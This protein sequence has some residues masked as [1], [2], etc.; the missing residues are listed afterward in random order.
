MLQNSLLTRVAPVAVGVGV[1]VVA[2]M[3]YIRP[4]L[5]PTK[6]AS[7]RPVFVSTSAAASSALSLATWERDEKTKQE[8]FNLGIGQPAPSLLPTAAVERASARLATYDSRH[9]LQ[10]VESAA[11][12]QARGSGD[13]RAG[14]DQW[15]PLGLT[16]LLL[17]SVG[18]AAS[19][20]NWWSTTVQPGT[21]RGDATR[22][23][24]P[25]LQAA[26]ATLSRGPVMVS[27]A[28]NRSD[29]ALV[30]RSCTRDG[31]LLHPGA[32]AVLMDGAVLARAQNR[33]WGEVWLAPTALGGRRR[34]GSWLDWTHQ[35]RGGRFC[36]CRRACGVSGGVCGGRTGSGAL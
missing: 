26:V 11:V 13:Y 5:R 32:P 1:G 14:N 35:G 10:S 33:P 34:A 28:V 21:T 16:A 36:A 25:R 31:T 4:R 8:F 6:F 24:Y 3:R 29:V 19:K 7:P 12:T 22:Q 2:V 9:V 15:Q 27:D 23:P 18:L 17:Y 20:D 30:L